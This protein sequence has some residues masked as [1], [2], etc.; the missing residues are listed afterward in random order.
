MW[1]DPIV[2]EVR[3]NRDKLAKKK[4]Y[5]LRKIFDDIQKNPVLRNKKDKN[6]I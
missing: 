6:R 2:E 4:N 3:K 1:K 5:S